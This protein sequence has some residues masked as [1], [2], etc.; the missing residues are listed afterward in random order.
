MTAAIPFLDLRAAYVEL[1]DEID[2]AYHRVMDSGW[3]IL[4]E[5]VEAFEREFAEY[6][7]VDH[8]VG[9]SN[10]MDALRLILDAYG[11][12]E[13]D[14]VIVPAHTFI[15]TWLAASQVG[16]KPVP[17]E[18]D[19]ATYN[20]D[21]NLIEAAITPK[22]KAIIPV[23]LYG[24]PADMDPILKLATAHDLLVIEDA[25][26][27]H[28]ATY[29]GR[30]TGSLGHAAAFSFYPGK[31]L[32]AFGDGGAVT[33]NNKALA[34]RVRTFRNYGSRK[35]YENEH[36]GL[37]CR[38]DPI[39]AAFLRVKLCYLDEWNTRR[40]HVAECY[41]E[42]LSN[43]RNL[44]PPK[45]LAAA[46]SA[47]HLFPVRIERRAE[48][49]RALV[50]LGVETLIHYPVPPHLSQAYEPEFAALKL[51]I[52]E[53]ICATVLSLP[54]GPHIRMDQVKTVCDSLKVCLGGCL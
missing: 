40:R 33:T 19:I 8:C 2:E 53:K 13:A 43:F 45:Q 18:P 36:K 23:H 52:T 12:G 5:E 37:N 26:Q 9:V 6:C 49:Q 29:Q 20:M 31:N 42:Q 24:Q 7:G 46:C 28:G 39:Q 11:I 35:K 47:W 14:E 17:V 16:A 51:P 38:L 32:G 27:A 34:D 48:I 50:S 10:G 54:I 1:K 44:V 3:Y 30:K 15:A 21:S 41:L 22:T 4:G 25:A